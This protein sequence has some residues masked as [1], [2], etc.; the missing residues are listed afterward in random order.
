MTRKLSRTWL[1]R[2]L[3]DRSG[4]GTGHLPLVGDTGTDARTGYPAAG[5][6]NLIGFHPPSRP[7]SA[8]AAT[9]AAPAAASVPWC[10]EAHTW[11]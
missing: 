5:P 8:S 3:V 6:P 4:S 10:W 11:G 9:A 7:R 1:A 2:S